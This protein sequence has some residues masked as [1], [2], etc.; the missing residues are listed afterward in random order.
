LFSALYVAFR[1]L[2]HIVA[3]V[4]QMFFFLTPVFWGME[5]LPAVHRWGLNLS[6]PEARD[7][8]LYANPMAAVMDGWRAI[9]YRH[10]SPAWQPLLAVAAEALV[11]LWISSAVFERRRE[12]F[13]E[14]V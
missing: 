13:A 10:E 9:F 7:L 12:E 14:L 11:L 3:N 1:D 6:Q 8:L 2:Q 5:T 4:I